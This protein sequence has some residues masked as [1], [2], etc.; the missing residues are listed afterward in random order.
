MYEAPV[1]LIGK[2]VTLLYHKHD[3]VR[4]EIT[5]EGKTYGFAVMLDVNVNYRVRRDNGSKGRDTFALGD[6]SECRYSGGKLFG[7]TAKEEEKP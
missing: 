2:R 4:M 5:F 1:G 6:D 3:P 7:K